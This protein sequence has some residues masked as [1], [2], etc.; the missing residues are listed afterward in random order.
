MKTYTFKLL[1]LMA[2]LA[3]T[4]ACGEDDNGVNGGTDNGGNGGAVCIE[5]DP[6]GNSCNEA[7]DCQVD[8]HCDDGVVTAGS[9]V[10]GSCASASEVCEDACPNMGAGAY[11]GKFCAVDGNGTGNGGNGGDNGGA[12]LGDIGDECQYDSDCE[13]DICIFEGGASWGYCSKV[14]E[15]WSDCP[16]FWDCEQL[17]NTTAKY[18]VQD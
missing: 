3:L 13:S 4:F 16:S 5:E 8:C 10:F 6:D 15:S 11:T 14:C 9:C 18:C 7:D 12:D 17:A 1:A 2:M